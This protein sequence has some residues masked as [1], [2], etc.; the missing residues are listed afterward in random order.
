MNPGFHF[1]LYGRFLGF[2]F[3]L[4]SHQI[5]IERGLISADSTFFFLLLFAL[6]VLG[7]LDF[8]SF[9]VVTLSLHEVERLL[10]NYW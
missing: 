9:L 7:S 8:L 3:F 4:F 10:V 6:I 5:L 1:L 2:F